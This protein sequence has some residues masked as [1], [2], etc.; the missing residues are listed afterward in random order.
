M[1]LLQLGLGVLSSEGLR[2]P[3]LELSGDLEP[4]SRRCSRR[5]CRGSPG[6]VSEYFRGKL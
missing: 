6:T 3:Q 2:P 4:L 1:L 5:I